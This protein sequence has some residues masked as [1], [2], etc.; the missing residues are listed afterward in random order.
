MCLQLGVCV[1]SSEI[2][3]K[4]GK[5]AKGFKSTRYIPMSN[6]EAVSDNVHGAG[7]KNTWATVHPGF[8][9]AKIGASRGEAVKLEEKWVEDGAHRDGVARVAANAERRT[10]TCVSLDKQGI[11]LE[12]C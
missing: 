4:I 8:S 5:I 2:L 9:L 6:C 10:D 3:E 11:K 12:C 1:D 7:S